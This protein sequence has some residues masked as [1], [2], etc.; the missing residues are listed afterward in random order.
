[1]YFSTWHWQQLVNG[2]SGFFPP[3]HGELLDRVHD[4]PSESS[5]AYLRSRGVSYVTLHGRFMHPVRFETTSA[6][7][8]A[9]PDVQ[10]VAK[11]PWHGAEA[12]LYRI[13]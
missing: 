4:F 10:L 8:D 5:L 7:L 3:S 11:S 1:M 13:Q 12:R 6:W 9:R 2:Y